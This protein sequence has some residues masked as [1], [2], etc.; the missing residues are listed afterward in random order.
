MIIFCQNINEIPSVSKIDSLTKDTQLRLEFPKE[1]LEKSEKKILRLLQDKLSDYTVFISSSTMVTLIPVVK[2]EDIAKNFD[3]IINALKDYINIS[4][5]LIKNVDENTNCKN[6][7][8][9]YEHPPHN[10]YENSVT[11]QIVETC[12][13]KMT[14]I[15]QIDSYFFG[16][17]ILSSNYPEIQ[18]L[19]NDTFHDTARIVDVV[20][21]NTKNSSLFN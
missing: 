7:E 4:N 6:W 18:I 8:L 17:F 11:G 13:Y 21:E 5:K 15:Y 20:S 3:S 9:T 14:T 1:I 10:R 2:K 19:I 12:D 16:Q